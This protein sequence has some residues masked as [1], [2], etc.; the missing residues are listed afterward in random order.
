M[1]RRS[2]LVFASLLVALALALPGAA[3]AKQGGT[4]RPVHGSITTTDTAS[5]ATGTGTGQGPALISHLGRGT[6]SHS[7]TITPT[8]AGPGGITL[9]L[10]GTDVFTAANG[11]QLF[12]TFAG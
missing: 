5:L 1:N 8:G 9:N 6:F 11:D 10:T 7:F 2:L 3:V 12:A 4:D